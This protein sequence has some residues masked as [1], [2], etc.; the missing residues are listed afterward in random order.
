MRAPAPLENGHSGRHSGLSMG[1]SRG[2]AAALAEIIR[3][4]NPPG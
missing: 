3:P 2:Q 1:S 4:M